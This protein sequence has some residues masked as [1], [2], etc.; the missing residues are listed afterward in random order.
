MVRAAS[1]SPL[2]SRRIMRET[3]F[4]K[5]LPITEMLP[6]APLATIENV[7]ASSPLIT[8]KRAGLFFIISST[9]SKLPLASLIAMIFSQSLA[10]RTVVSALRFTPV[11]PGTL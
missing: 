10:K 11:R 8:S 1:Y 5:A 3:S 2:N 4:G 6:A 7:R 9:C